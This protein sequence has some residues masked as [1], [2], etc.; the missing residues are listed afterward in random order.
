MLPDYTKRMWDSLTQ[1]KDRIEKD[2][3]EKVLEF[4]GHMLVTDHRTFRLF[5]RL[6]IQ[7][8]K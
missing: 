8:E 5:D 7:E 4:N 2:G 6:L 3:K 1:L